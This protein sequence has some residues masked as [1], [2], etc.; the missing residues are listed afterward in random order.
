MKIA[1]IQSALVWENPT[2]NRTEFEKKIS[3]LNTDIELIVL[4]EMFST[5]FTMNTTKIAE[6][7]TGDTVVWMQKIAKSRNCAITGSVVITENENYYNRLLFVSPSGSIQHYDKRH[8]FTLAGE[9]KIYSAGNQ[10]LIV[11]YLGWKICLLVCYDLRFPVF[12]RNK[13]NYDLL[14]YVANWPETRI[15]AWD[16]L[17]RARAIE[18][19]CYTIGVNR[20]GQDANHLS[21]NGHSQL[22]APLG[23]YCIAPT[24]T[25]SIFVDEIDLEL[26]R[27]TRQQFNFLNDG[28]TFKIEL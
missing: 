28:D 10:K 16:S 26:V 20:V 3:D 22:I 5:G 23:E 14:V 7:M 9:E 18:N 13:E 4:P 27:N 21:Y 15:L 24:E 8:L 2:V 6:T 17:L 19:L 11:N 1:L 12:S 25:E